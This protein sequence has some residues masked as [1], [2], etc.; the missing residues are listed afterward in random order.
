MR[1]TSARLPSFVTLTLHEFVGET[2]RHA[3]CSALPASS[4]C[5]VLLEHASA[6]RTTQQTSNIGQLRATCV[7]AAARAGSQEPLL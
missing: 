5:S 7:R 4:C 1:K 2:A 6:A 3:R